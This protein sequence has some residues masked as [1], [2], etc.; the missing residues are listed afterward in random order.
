MAT[1]ALSPGAANY[2]LMPNSLHCRNDELGAFLETGGP[3]RGHDLGLGIKT[4]RVRPVLVEVAEAGALP[5]AESVIRKRHR[6]RHINAHHAHLHTAG[7]IARRIAV[8][9]EDRNAVAVF[10]LRRQPQSLVIIL[11]AHDRQD[12]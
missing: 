5:A 6:D 10:V 2:S 7:E 9:G 12:R 8:T 4:D 11:G 1:P 3:A